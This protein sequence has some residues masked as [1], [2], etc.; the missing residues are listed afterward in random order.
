MPNHCNNLLLLS[1]DEVQIIVDNYIREDENGGKYFD[2]EKIIPVGEI[3]SWYFERVEKWGTKWVGYDLYIGEDN[4]E[5]FTAWSPPIGIIEKLAELHKDITFRLEYYEAGMNYR[6]VA[7]AKWQDG[8]V[9][10]D[11]KYWDMTK[12]DLIELGLFDE[13]SYNE[14]IKTQGGKLCITTLFSWLKRKIL[15]TLNL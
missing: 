10:F 12:E 8:K 13:D 6:G 2:F 14:Y 9:L 3:E 4:I 1:N 5:F 7:T 11:D 15:K